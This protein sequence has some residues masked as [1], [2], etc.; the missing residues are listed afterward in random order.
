MV[1]A[2]KGS[3]IT[4]IVLTGA[5]ENEGHTVTFTDIKGGDEM[6]ITETMRGSTWQTHGRNWSMSRTVD[7]N[8][9]I[10]EQDKLIKFGYTRYS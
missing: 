3:K 6:K 10:E 7:L 4:G 8:E 2:I 9:A 5:W 1:T